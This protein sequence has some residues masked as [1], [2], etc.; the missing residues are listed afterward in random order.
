MTAPTIALQ[1]TGPGKAATHELFGLGGRTMQVAEYKFTSGTSNYTS[2]GED[3]SSIWNDFKTVLAV[4]V[5][6]VTATINNRRAF[7]V[8]L[9][10]KLLLVYSAFNT[11]NTGADLSTIC[12]DVR[13]LVVGQK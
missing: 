10:N 6:Q 2:G 11:E 12:D 3:I 7:T 4:H 8:D 1:A 5:Q 9:T 13:L